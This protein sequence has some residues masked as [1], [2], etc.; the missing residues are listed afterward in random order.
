MYFGDGRCLH[1]SF[2]NR[3]FTSCFKGEKTVTNNI[4]NDKKALS[5]I[6][7]AV[8]LIS[9]TFVVAVSV[10]FWMGA[11]VGSYT[12]FEQIELPSTYAQWVNTGS[13]WNVTIELRNT[14]S[15]DANLTE[16][17]VNDVPLKNYTSGL[18]AL[19]YNNN[20][21]LSSLNIKISQGNSVTVYVLLGQSIT[22]GFT[23]GTTTSIKLHTAAGKDYSTSVKLP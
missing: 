6:I 9:V 17:Y 12:L 22:S 3:G 2:I 1:N 14:G 13:R 18:V 7:A 23:A 5:P 21:T 8:I 16:V 15:A 10:A 20:Q 19:Y 11:I 4:N